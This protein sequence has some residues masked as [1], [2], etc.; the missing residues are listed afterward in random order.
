MAADELLARGLYCFCMLGLGGNL[1]I[2]FWAATGDFLEFMN[3]I[4]SLLI[5]L[6]IN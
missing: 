3:L 6:E 4:L 5:E 1:F 2:C